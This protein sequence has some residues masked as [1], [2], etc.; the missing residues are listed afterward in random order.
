MSVN[1]K[2][3][4]IEAS[5]DS[6]FRGDSTSYNPEELLVSSLSSCHMLWYLHLCSE[7][8]IRVLGYKDTAQ[9]TMEELDDGSGK[10]KEVI[11]YPEVEIDNDSDKVL[12]EKLHNMAHK[13]C[14]IANLC[15]FDVKHE[16]RITVTI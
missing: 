10:F 15:N 6:S 1:N 3:H 9:G 5:S 11:L 2:S 13:M 16:P 14:F 8:N 12:A 4:S 7:N